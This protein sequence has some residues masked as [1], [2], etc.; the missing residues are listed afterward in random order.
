MTASDQIVSD[1][2]DFL[3][4]NIVRTPAGGGDLM[5]GGVKYF[6]LKLSTQKG[7]DTAAHRTNVPIYD[8]VPA[9]G[10]TELFQAY[11][12]PYEDNKM[13]SITVAAGA[14]LMFTAPMDGCTFGVGSAAPTGERRVAHINL[15]SQANSR[16]KQRAI[17]KGSR[18][19]ETMVEPDHYMLPDD[20][21]NPFGLH[22]TTFGVRDKKTKQWR[23]YYQQSKVTMGATGR[24]YELLGV[25][26]I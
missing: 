3:T 25:I 26:P 22:V 14:N 13:H 15:K 24:A 1:A 18:M 8:L 9:T 10:G 20:K 21:A 6:T 17:L 5:N 7:T 2:V 11:W 23:F 19:G 16:G 4:N 12:C